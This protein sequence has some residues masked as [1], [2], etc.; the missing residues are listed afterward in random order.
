MV[1]SNQYSIRNDF[2]FRERESL[3]TIMLPLIMK[4]QNQI[5]RK[6]LTTKK[7]REVSSTQKALPLSNSYVWKGRT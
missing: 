6:K 5:K 7:A 3:W 1:L 2:V 4:P